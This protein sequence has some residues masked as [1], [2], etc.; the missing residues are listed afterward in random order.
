M[1]E[2]LSQQFVNG[3]TQGVAYAFV[4]L[5]LTM[6]FGV[7]HVVNFAQ[8]EFYMLG[9]LV[10][11]VLVRT[12]GVP[13]LAGVPL[14]IAAVV[15]V[16]WVVDRLAVGPVLD[17]RDGNSMVL[18]TTFAFS[19]LILHTVLGAWGPTPVRIDGIRG[20]F[21]LGPVYISAQRLLV[22]A[23]GVAALAAIEFVLRRTIIGKQIRALAQ[24]PFAASVVGINVPLVRTVTFL[25]A[26]GLAGFAGALL[27]PVTLFTPTMGQHVIINAFV[28][29]VIGGMGN[30]FGA[31][32][33]GLLLG[34]LQSYASTF[35]PQ[36]VGNALIYA[37]LLAALLV[38][39]QGLFSG[40][41]A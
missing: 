24:S 38:R 16:A 23:A 6:I 4:A 39:P 20:G 1:L 34:I 31:V 10:A 41:H 36:E 21:Q 17:E 22:L 3:L 15:I 25:G 26:A 2:L 5:G 35:L 33:C 14:A 19:L 27:I 30:A 18:L 29:V 7:L 12:L 28:I 32:T 13:Y 9:G 37:L 11:V 8:G 40:R